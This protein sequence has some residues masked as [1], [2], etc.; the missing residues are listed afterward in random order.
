VK[1]T[2]SYDE[3]PSGIS[4][5]I[6]ETEVY[7]SYR[8]IDEN[9]NFV[10]GA[11]HSFDFEINPN[12]AHYDI[13]L[14]FPKPV[15]DWV[16]TRL[17]FD[18]IGGNREMWEY[19]EYVVGNSKW[20]QLCYT[21]PWGLYIVVCTFSDGTAMYSRFVKEQTEHPDI[22]IY[23]SP[24]PTQGYF[25]VH[26]ITPVPDNTP[27]VVRVMNTMGLLFF[28]DVVHIDGT[29]LQLN[30]AHAP[31]GTYHVIIHTAH[32]TAVARFFKQ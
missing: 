17:I 14:H 31:Q 10:V 16:N 5:Q 24:N 26:F 32:G 9:Y 23:V 11:E 20:I 2:V 15:H 3:L 21:Q 18:E 8:I 12:P 7:S 28:E 4:Y 22:E 19:D 29:P 6:T 1:Q 25:N 27:A 30:V 13:T